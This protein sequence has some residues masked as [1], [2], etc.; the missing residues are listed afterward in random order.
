MNNFGAA[1]TSAHSQTKWTHILPI[2]SLSYYA[3]DDS[4]TYITYSKGY[5]PGGYNYR[6]TDTLVPF[7][8]ESTNSL[9]L[10]HKRVLNNSVTFNSALFYNLIDKLRINTFD[11][12]LATITLNADKAYSYGVEFDLHYKRENLNMY[13]TCGV[14]KTQM[15]KID[16]SPQYEGN[17]II[18]V[19]NITASFGAKYSF[20]HNY[21]V[22]SNLKYMG[23]RYYNIS[24]SA[25]ESGYTVVNVGLG[26]KK[27]GLEALVYANNLFDKEYVDFM[28]YTPSNNYY[29]FGNPRVLGF[30]VSQSF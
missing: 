12:N 16:T 8:P 4:H 2:L 23:E 3:E 27:D 6:T 18:D 11:D 19:P 1:T 20:T 29:H 14:T 7:E 15:Q 25:K 22:Q 5:R 24:N 28:I 17:N 30:K 21:Y 13:A 9:E 10:G 26:Y